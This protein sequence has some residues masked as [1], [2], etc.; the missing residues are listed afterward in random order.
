MAL[1]WAANDAPSGGRFPGE[2]VTFLDG[3]VY[4]DRGLGSAE[5]GGVSLLD[6]DGEHRCRRLRGDFVLLQYSPERAQGAI[7]RDHLGGR[8]LVWHYDGTRLAFASEVRHLLRMLDARPAPDH[9]AVSHWLALSAPP[10]NRTMYAGVHRLPAGHVLRFGASPPTVRRYWTPAYRPV[11]RG[12]VDEHVSGLRAVLAEAVRRRCSASGDTGVLLSGGLDSS[13]VAALAT[14]LEPGRRP[15]RAYSATFPAHP[16]VDEGELIDLLGRQLGLTGTRVA[17]RSGSVLAGAVGYIEHW[18]VPPLSPN[19]F[20]W[21]PLLHRARAD[22]VAALLDGEGGDELF[23]LSPYLMADRLR[24]GRVAAARRLARTV[25]GGGPHVDGAALWR[26]LREFGVKG[27]APAW[28]HDSVR[29]WRGA[30]RYTP[31]WLRPHVQRAFA[32]SDLATEWKR[33]PG[34]RWWAYL[35]TATAQ[36]LAPAAAYDHI[37]RRAALAGLE[38]RHPLVDVDVI[39]FAL[40]L[41]PDLAYDTRHSRPVLREAMD[42]LLP[43]E[44]RLRPTKSSF[45]AIF[46]EALTGDDLPVARALLRPGEA[47]VGAYVDLELVENRL[48]ANPPPPGGR[49]EW[50]IHLWRLLTAECW[51]RAQSH[52]TDVAAWRLPPLAVPQLALSR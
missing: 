46:H 23:G 27:A 48:L 16:T 14:G 2:V 9:T 47:E 42:G 4:D 24:R 10:A 5:P 8:S 21:L 20:F 49:M 13:T 35:V 17:V 26:L 37:R 51:L 34:P 44:V 40:G 7:A 38:A 45:D 12:S 25:P 6:P 43:D 22:G 31:A 28:L 19:L 11:R 29:R 18:Q 30:D 32:E 15:T 1:S 52:P 50:A 3:V 41:P 33:L 36:G 39:D